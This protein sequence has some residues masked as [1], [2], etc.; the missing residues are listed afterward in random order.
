VRKVDRGRFAA[1]EL[2]I[3]RIVIGQSGREPFDD[4][5]QI[6]LPDWDFSSL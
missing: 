3:E 5:G 2:A 6:A 1:P 4:F